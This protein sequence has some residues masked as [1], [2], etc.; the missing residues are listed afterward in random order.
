MSKLVLGSAPDS[1]GVWFAH[2]PRQTPFGRFLDELSRAGYEWLELGPYG[3]LPTDPAALRHELGT[4][5]L[6]VSA[7]T[8]A[9]A[10]HR[11]DRW[12]DA[13][14]ECQN[15]AA[16]AATLGARHVVFLPSMYRDASGA[17]VDERRL[18]AE[19]WRALLRRATELG[20]ML[21]DGHGVQLCVHPHADSH[22]ETQDEIERFLDGTDSRYVQLCLDIGH[23]AYGGGD[24]LGLIGRFAERIAYVHVKQIDPAVLAQVREEQLSFAQAVERGVCV[25]PPAGV[26]DSAA[27]VRALAALRRPI[28][29]IA[30]HDLYPCDP[31]VPLPIAT[32]T[33]AYLTGCVGAGIRPPTERTLTP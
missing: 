2:D 31:D 19:A 27:V 26:P 18:T 16:L 25:E 13:V 30:E 10:L 29:V 32:R 22:I 20:Q 6:R 9:G 1:W 4:R 14:D 15:V 24:S 7:G 33:R 8:A 17:Y 21:L 12:P 23:V 3:Y 5:G 11:D 28:F